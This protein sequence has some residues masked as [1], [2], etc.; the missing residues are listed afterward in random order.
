[1]AK[2][3]F[4]ALLGIEEKTEWEAE[5]LHETVKKTSSHLGD[6]YFRQLCHHNS[7]FLKE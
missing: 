1:L 3:L 6:K 2:E 4:D 7:K 5:L